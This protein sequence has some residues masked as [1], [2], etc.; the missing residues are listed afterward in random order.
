M[1]LRVRGEGN[2]VV[3][4]HVEPLVGVDRPR[5]RAVDVRARGVGVNRRRPPRARTRRRRGATRCSGVARVCDRA[6]RIESAG[7][8]LAG[9][10]AEDRRLVRP[11]PSSSAS[12]RPLSSAATTS[13]GAP[14]PSMRSARSIVPWR[15]SPTTT[16]IRG[17]PMSPSRSTF[18][19]T[20]WRTWCRAAARAVKVAVCP[21]VTNPND[22]SVGSPSSSISQAPATSS[23][24]EAAGRRRTGRRSG[25][26]ST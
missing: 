16:R 2:A 18:Q 10:G 6:E 22:A 3:V 9:L 8:D 14:S 21:P 25:P 19:P 26:T 15:F 11:A 7:A 12:M 23:T 5:V 1:R 13:V 24:T 17:A 4:G 20:F